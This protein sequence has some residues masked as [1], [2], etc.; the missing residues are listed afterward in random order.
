[1]NPY[2][3]GAVGLGGLLLI[4]ESASA[5]SPFTSAGDSPITYSDNENLNAYLAVLRLGESS[6]NYKALYG[7]GNFASYS[8]H[9][10]INQ[11]FEGSNN[12]HA[13]GAYQF[14]PQTWREAKEALSLPDFSP[15]SQD[16]AAV[17]LLRR[18]GAYRAV[19]A[20]DVDAAQNLLVN[21]WA[22]LSD[23]GIDWV[24]STFT[25]NGGTLS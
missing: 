18:R 20:G 9:P 11:G 16:R 12:S 7:G 25:A 22:A 17:F 19:L 10:A 21:E 23:R 3:I 1:M 14:Q 15:D 4:A 6:N 13:A 5:F 24:R 2:L 8:D